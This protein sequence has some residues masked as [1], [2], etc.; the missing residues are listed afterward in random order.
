MC[1]K[2]HL[3]ILYSSSRV[4]LSDV[5]RE[6][7]C[8][9]EAWRF[10]FCESFLCLKDAAKKIRVLEGLCLFVMRLYVKS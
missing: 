2:Y 6:K 8:S 9:Y 1:P 10:S 5:E 7:S 4:F 3:G